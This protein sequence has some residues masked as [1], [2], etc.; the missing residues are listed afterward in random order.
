MQTILGSSGVI[1]TQLAK[2]LASYT[3]KIRLVS[4]NPQKVNDSDELF[5][6]DLTIP[7][8]VEKSIEGSD[9]VYLTIGFPYR[10]TRWKLDWPPVMQNVINACKYYKAKLVFF[11]NIYMYDR[12]HIGHMT[13]D[14]P[15]RPT[16]K[17]GEI[18]AKIAKNLWDELNHG[19]IDALI[20]RSA[21]FIGPKNSIL[22]ELVYNNLHKGKKAIWLGDS[23]KIHNFTNTTDAAKGTAILGNTPEAYNQIWHL[24]TDK[25]NMTGKLWIDLFAKEMNAKST[26]RE[27]P[28]W[29]LVPMGIFKP[30]LKEIK[31]MGYQYDRDYFFDSSKF[32]HKFGYT[33]IKPKESVKNITNALQ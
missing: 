33:P 26:Y 11:D 14:T 15:V 22:V 5:K 12:Y 1:G 25:T 23:H 2:E 7:H 10:Y 20:A 30:I 27:I 4:R 24:P 28:L 31:E 21:D 3:D 32:E 13:E 17:K 16:S 18:R 19:K 8:E 6:A 9:I 29:L